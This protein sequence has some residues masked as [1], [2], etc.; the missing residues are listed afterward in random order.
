MS[1]PPAP[2]KE[3]ANPAEAAAKPTGPDGVVNVRIHEDL[4]L[5]VFLDR[6]QFSTGPID[7]NPGPTFA[8]VSQRY[9]E[10]RGDVKDIHAF[11]EKARNTVGNPITRY[12]LRTEDFR[13]IAEPSGAA[14]QVVRKSSKA[15]ARTELPPLTY[16]QLASARVL[17]YRSAWEFIAE[18]FHCDESFLR[19]LNPRIKGSP[20]AGTIFQVP[21]VIPFEIEKLVESPLQ[22]A[23][24]P[25]KVMTATLVELARLEIYEGEKLVA[26]MPTALARPD[27]RGRGSWTV[28]DAIPRPKLATLQELKEEPKAPDSI[29]GTATVAS[30]KAT[31]AAEQFLAAGPNNPVGVVWINLAK[32]KSTEALPYGLHGTSIPGRM[33][34]QEGIGGIR[35]ANWDIA[36][37]VRLLPPGTA[38]QWK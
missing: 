22:P 27:L 1:P 17:T 32:A 36:R 31:L 28:L 26:V 6:E 2:K 3:A 37:A 7:G 12:A 20:A 15:K 11:V 10:T 33:K 21:N 5:Q 35:L 30:P 13:F 14:N 19:S 34:T 16:Q 18:R 29:D 8:T 23:A 9:R 4:L 38:L 25:Q 24:D